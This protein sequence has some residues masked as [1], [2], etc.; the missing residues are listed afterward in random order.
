M[1]CVQAVMS[2]AVTV[3]WPFLPLFVLELGVRTPHDASLWAG[4]I[5]ST[6]FLVAAL[7][8]PFW[9]AVAD[10]HGRK[11]MVLRTSSSLAVFTCLMGFSHNVYQL[12]VLSTLYGLFS[13]FAASAIA[14]VATSVPEERLGFAL[15]W[16]STA[17]LAGTLIGPLIGGF[18]A[19]ALHSYRD[20][21]WVSSVAGFV[22]VAVAAIFVHEHR[23]PAPAREEKREGL[24][25]SLRETVRHPQLAPLFLV[26]LLAQASATA[27]APVI[28]PFVKTLLPGSPWIATASGAAIAITGIADLLVSPFLGKRSDRIGYR[29]VLLVSVG[30]AAAFTI[31]QAFTHSIWVFLALRFGVGAFLGGILPTANAW[32]GRLFSVHERGRVYGVS[33]SAASLGMFFGPLLGGVVASSLGFGVVFAIVGG[34]M[35]C[36]LL[37]IVFGTR[38]EVRSVGHL[39]ASSK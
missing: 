38:D 27:V 25:A 16:M 21:F 14:L 10:R 6:Q 31:P 11:A 29:R 33:A 15:G 34:L 37:W 7:V 18:L 24:I 3:S 1:V 20:V 36:N 23:R 19:D 30:C 5:A 4:I 17:Q 22:G 32:I 13:G 26:L 9:G 35:L 39:Q 8:S 12:L 28:A 2:V